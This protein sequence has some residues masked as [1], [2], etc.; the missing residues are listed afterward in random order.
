[1]SFFA[2]HTDCVIVT[3]GMIQQGTV[4]YEDEDD[5]DSTDNDAEITNFCMMKS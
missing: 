2:F 4:C 1:M 5:E 3:I